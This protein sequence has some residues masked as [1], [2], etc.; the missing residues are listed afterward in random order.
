MA[1]SD[2]RGLGLADGDQAT[3]R[4]DTG[5]AAVRIRIA[6]IRAG[7]VQMFFPEANVLVAPGRRDE[8]SLV[9]DY[10]AVVR[11]EAGD[12]TGSDGHVGS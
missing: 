2:A 10:N 11:I 7:N 6:P 8:V 5:R 4:S 12:R 1:E 9:P 3:A